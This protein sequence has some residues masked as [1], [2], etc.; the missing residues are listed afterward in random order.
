MIVIL[1]NKCY[2]EAKFQEFSL[3]A[4]TMIVKVN[5]VEIFYQKTGQGHPL[6]LLHGNGLEHSIFDELTE[7]LQQHYTVYAM[8]SRNHGQS[9]AAQDYSYDAMAE[10]VYG[11][12]QELNLGKVYLLGFSDGAV[13]AL[14][15]ALRHLDALEKVAF[16][17]LNLKPSDLN[18]KSLAYYRN[19]YEKTGNP[20]FKLVLESPFIELEELRAITI[21]VLLMAAEREMF[22]DGLFEELMSGFPDVRGKIMLGHKHES[23]LVHT[24]LV[25]PDLLD[26]FG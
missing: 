22:R 6:V 7:K 16:L 20:L 25:Y 23:Y 11:L 15:V 3:E 1:Q 10:D 13:I 19:N 9:A 14:H 2:T 18:E 4:D 21:P 17:G 26:F 12:I 24:D 5:G 8:D